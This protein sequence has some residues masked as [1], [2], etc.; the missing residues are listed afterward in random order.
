[1][2]SEASGFGRHFLTAVPGFDTGF[3]FAVNPAAALSGKG[4]AG[5]KGQQ[6]ADEEECFQL[7]SQ[8]KW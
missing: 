2:P 3:D 7:G 5:G 6:G 8:R 1:M 4:G